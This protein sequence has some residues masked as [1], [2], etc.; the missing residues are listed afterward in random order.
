MKLL[1]LGHSSYLLEMENADGRPV[2]L[3]GDPWLSDYLIGDLQ[4]RFPRLRFESADLPPLDAIFLSHSHTDHLDPY[5]LLRLWDELESRPALLLPESL[6]FLEPLL[7]EFLE[8]VE[9]C[10]LRDQVET[11]FQGVTLMAFFNPEVRATNEDDVMVL[12]VRNEREAFLCESDAV[13]PLYDPEVRSFVA[14]TL[15]APK[16][17]TSCFLTI[18][19]EGDA[20][21]AMLA[22]GDLNDRQQRLSG[23]IERTYAEIYELYAAVDTEAED[24][25]WGSSRLV[26]LVG[27]QGI[28]FPQKLETEWNRVLFP[29]RLEDRVRFEA[30]VAEQEG[31]AHSVAEFIPGDVF[32]LGGGGLE[33]RESCSFLKLLD[34][35]QDRRFDPTLELFDEFPQAPLRADARDT[36]R[37]QERLLAALNDRF[38]PHLIGARNPPVEHLLAARGGEY[39]IRLRLGNAAG[40][41]DVDFRLGF[42][43]L[44]FQPSPVAGEPEEFYWANDVEDVLDG[45]SD[46]FS[47]FCRRPLGG[48]ALRFWANLGLPY[49]NNDLIERKLRRHFERARAGASLEDW[50][51]S[52]HRQTSANPSDLPTTTQHRAPG[53]DTN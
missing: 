3:L 46:E 29:I 30:E 27:G 44:R 36:V 7:R 13:L 12:T 31:C 32:H 39:R 2:R 19:N 40:H 47:T 24:E 15:C 20:T 35:P 49:L 41:E 51:L 14:S 48:S 5:A 26:R 25:L 18:K 4:G 45:R 34:A 33:K 38:L 10:F 8:G 9:I 17:E 53:A 16:I 37:Q 21:M 23:S 1:S 28:C 42:D 43:V 50:V 11:P 52:F 22:A 6:R